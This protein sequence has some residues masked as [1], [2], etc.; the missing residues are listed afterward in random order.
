MR[1]NRIVSMC[2]RDWLITYWCDMITIDVIGRVLPMFWAK[3]TYSN[4]IIYIIVRVNSASVE[5]SAVKCPQC[6]VSIVF[7]EIILYVD[8]TVSVKYNM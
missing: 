3:H 7:V 5:C 4:M 1:C 2:A 6:A 8:E